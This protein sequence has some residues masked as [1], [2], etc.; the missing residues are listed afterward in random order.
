MKKDNK[1]ATKNRK[2]VT[3]KDLKPKADSQVKGGRKALIG[4]NP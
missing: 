4:P 3:V 2:K 1:K